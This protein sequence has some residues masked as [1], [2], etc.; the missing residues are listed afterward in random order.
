MSAISRLR[1]TNYGVTRRFIMDR[2]ARVGVIGLGRVGLPL[3]MQLSRAGFV[4]FGFDFDSA[5]TNKLR[6]RKSY[7]WD[8]D[9]G[10]E[11][12]ARDPG[13]HTTDDLSQI[14]EAGV[15]IVCFPRVH[16]E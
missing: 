3:A 15:L 14:A 6:L 9:V 12:T 5:R 4:V 7:I 11:E 8:F 1:T 2:T 10:P 16:F 13:I